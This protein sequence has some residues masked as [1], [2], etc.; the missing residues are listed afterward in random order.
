MSAS[1]AVPAITARKI[2]EMGPELTLVCALEGTEVLIDAGRRSVGR[3]DDLSG[4]PRSAP[5]VVYCAAW[6]CGAGRAFAAELKRAGHTCVY[7]YVGGLSE[8]ILLSRGGDPEYALK[9]ASGGGRPAT[10]E[11]VDRAFEAMHH[12]YFEKNGFRE[13]RAQPE[14]GGALAAAAVAAALALLANHR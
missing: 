3:N 2:L 1:A 11:E 6:S 7:D 12:A 5:V 10:L 4:L 9:A 14:R 8:W 13:C